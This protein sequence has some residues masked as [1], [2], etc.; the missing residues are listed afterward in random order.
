MYIVERMITVPSLEESF[1]QYAYHELSDFFSWL[2]HVKKLTKD[3]IECLRF[4]NPVKCRL[5][6]I[7]DMIGFHLDVPYNFSPFTL[8]LLA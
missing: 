7:S 8:D 4:S 6:V 2:P 1:S 5:K 3:D